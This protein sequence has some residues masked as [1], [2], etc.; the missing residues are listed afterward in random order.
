MNK[1]CFLISRHF[2]YLIMNLYFQQAKKNA[3]VQKVAELDNLDEYPK[4]KIEIV[5]RKLTGGHP[6]QILLDELKHGRAYHGNIMTEV[7]KCNYK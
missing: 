5:R 2:I 7:Q 1:C 3:V 4:K 6:C